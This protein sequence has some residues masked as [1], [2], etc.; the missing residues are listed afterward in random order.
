MRVKLG[1]FGPLLLEVGILFLYSTIR[2]QV[3]DRALVAWVVLLLFPSLFLTVLAP[4]II[5]KFAKLESKL[6]LRLDT[7]LDNLV[8]ADRGYES[9]D[10]TRTLMREQI[11]LQ[12]A[13]KTTIGKS[14]KVKLIP[15]LLKRA[16][17][18]YKDTFYSRSTKTRPTNSLEYFESLTLFSSLTS[19]LL[20][21]NILVVWTM[22]FTDVDL[23]FIKLD[24]VETPGITISLSIIFILMLI[25]T[26]SLFLYA[27]ER[28][29]SYLPYVVPILF[30]EPVDEQYLRRETIRSIVSYNM[31]NLVDRR[32]QKKYKDLFSSAIDE[33]LTPLVRDEFLITA[34][35]EFAHKIAWRE[36]SSI[37]NSGKPTDDAQKTP[38]ER[39]F[40]GDRI[41]KLRLDEK[42]LLGL[43]SDLDY[44]SSNLQ[45]WDALNN[46]ERTIV[47]FQ[48]YR[49]IEFI[50][51]EITL[52]LD[53]L[54][55]D[56]E[57]N[58]YNS[59]TALFE[60]GYLT[61]DD[62]KNLHNLRY[63]RNK[64][65]HEPGIRL[66]VSNVSVL[67]ILSTLNSTLELIG[68]EKEEES[69]AKA[70]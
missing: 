41:G 15:L 9:K 2:Y 51:R 56:S 3:L 7:E 16:L 40:H 61:K 69:P 14:I 26:Y 4:F 6:A 62:K 33:L 45:K 17:R 21:L 1:I 42:D 31:D 8:L 44:I 53:L 49:L 38:L 46:E 55:E 67:E 57:Y 13:H 19:I 68:I 30:N 29:L 54:L 24:K 35:T 50:Y 39:L 20:S 66:D 5:T 60:I 27:R 47:Y 22:H 64:L 10:E 65:M 25:L 28:L 18:H 11:F 36:Y 58:L 34:R 63:R 59:I 23:Y 48:V 32:D 43:N 37:Q 12:D 70:N 52:S